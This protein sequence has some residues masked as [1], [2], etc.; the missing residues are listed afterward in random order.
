M[1]ELRGQLNILPLNH[2]SFELTAEKP[3]IG[4]YRKDQNVLALTLSII[5]GKAKGERSA[6][7]P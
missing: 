4:H 6:D 1:R 5:G 7:Y 2:G 3:A